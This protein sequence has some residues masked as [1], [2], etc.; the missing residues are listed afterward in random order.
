MRLFKFISWYF[1]ICTSP[2]ASYI[3]TLDQEQVR[4]QQKPELDI[5]LNQWTL[6]TL[7]GCAGNR[8][9]LFQLQSI[10]LLK[11]CGGWSQDRIDSETG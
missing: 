3:G 5:R 10:L 2:F 7:K 9:Q 8:L 6:E 4:S 1:P 11:V